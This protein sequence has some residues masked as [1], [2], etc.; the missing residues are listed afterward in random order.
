MGFGELGGL[1][2]PWGCWDGGA[3]RET[4]KLCTPSHMPCSLH[5]FYLDVHLYL[6]HILTKVR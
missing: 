1:V 4:W 5:L 3:P 2:N 6:Y